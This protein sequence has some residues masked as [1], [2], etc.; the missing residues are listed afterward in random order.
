MAFQDLREYIEALDKRGL[1]RRIKAPV[2][3]H[4][5]ISEITDRVVKASGPALLFENVVGHSMPVATNL[6]GTEERM[7]L[8]LGVSRLDDVASRLEKLLE[9]PRPTTLL[10]KLATLPLLAK[11]GAFLPR[12]VKSGPSQEIVEKENASLAGLPINQCWPDDGGRY[13]TMGLVFTRDPVKKK[14]NLGMY[15]IQVYDERT[16]GMHWQIHKHG[17]THEAAWRERGERRMPVAVAIGADPA[18]IYAATAPLPDGVP[19]VLFA[20]F[21]REQP[22]EL[23]RCVTSDLEVPA[24][25]EIILEGWVDPEER[26]IEGPF[27]DH[28]GYYS[29]PE[30]YPVFHIDCIT[31]RRDAI[32]NTTLVGIPPMEDYFLGKATERIFLPLMRLH[33]P[34]IVDINFPAEGVFH[35]CCLISI[36]KRY[37]GQARKVM[38]AL[39]GLGQM[40][41]TKLLIVLDDD[42]DLTNFSEVAWRVLS[43]IDA[44]RDVVIVDGPVDALDHASPHPLFGAKMGID[45]TRKGPEEGMPRT[46]PP[47]ARMSQEVR[48]RVTARWKEFGL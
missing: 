35:N 9:I 31:R 37:P 48:E 19:E 15:R 16:C 5:E 23:V 45:V 18:L 21:L 42:V 29:A 20:G 43:N 3:A 36:R 26:R 28:N 2:D 10:D 4:L 47:E 11:V 44:R 34:E 6:F 33:L 24:R 17:R 7:A 46:W 38:S 30:E 12:H 25:A 14:D 41:F 27:G 40:M 1:L 13:I 39:W 22:V 8:A 32:Y